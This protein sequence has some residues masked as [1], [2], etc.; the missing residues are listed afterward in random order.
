MTVGT[1]DDG[2]WHTLSGMRLGGRPTQKGVY[3]HGG[4][5]VVK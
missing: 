2:A 4:K 3:V 1:G 5:K